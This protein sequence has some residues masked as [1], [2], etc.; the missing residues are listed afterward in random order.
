LTDSFHNATMI[1]SGMGPVLT[2]PLTYTGRILSSFY[3]LFSGVIFITS[4]GFILAPAV[5]HLFH[6]L[7]VDES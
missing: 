5:Q 7:H 6:S 1:L 3:A 4:V 2:E